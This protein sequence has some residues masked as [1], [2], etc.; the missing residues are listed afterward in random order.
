M[1]AI[2]EVDHKLR[3]ITTTWSGVA[4]DQELR[5]ALVKYQQEVKN[6]PELRS[7]H[8]L[9]DFTKT[10]S[11]KLTPKGLTNLA[12]IASQTDV[13]G[14]KTRLAIVVDMPLAYGMGLTYE[15]YRG[16]VSKSTKE[17]RVFKT[18]REALAWLDD[19][20]CPS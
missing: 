19:G 16:L 15:T 18:H 20:G 6:R 1:P 9:V 4:D 5:A 2:H 7:Y 3:L 11:F 10:S 8:E 13:K 14:I 17:V 12:G